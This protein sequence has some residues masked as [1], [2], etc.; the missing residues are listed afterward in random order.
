M[1]R[2]E[3]I[4]KKQNPTMCPWNPVVISVSYFIVSPPL[5]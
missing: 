3:T 4:A 5:N 2:Q 1:A